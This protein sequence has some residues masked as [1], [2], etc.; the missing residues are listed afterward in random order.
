MNDKANVPGR[1][2][3]EPEDLYRL[4]EVADV[5]LSQPADQVVF[6]VAWPDRETDSNRAVLH[7]V[8][9]DGTNHRVLTEGHRDVDPRFS[10]DGTK[11]AFARL[12]PKQPGRLMVM[13]WPLGEV[14][15]VAQFADG[16]PGHIRWLNGDRLL[17]IA[18]QRPS[19]QNGVDDDEL[20]RR[21]RVISTNRYRFDG[22]GYI[23]DRPNQIWLIDL[24]GQADGDAE[25]AAS[26]AENNDR[27]PRPVGRSGFDHRSFAVAPDG[28]S[29][30]ATAVSDDDPLQ[31]AATRVWRYPLPPAAGAAGGDGPDEA[32]LLTPEKG[33]WDSLVWHDDGDLWALGSLDPSETQFSQMFQVDLSGESSPRAVVS[34]DVNIN[35]WGLPGRGLIKLDD[36]LLA[37]GIRRGRLAIDHYAKTSGSSSV[38]YEDDTQIRA[39]DADPTGQ[40]VVAA[41]TSPVRPAELWR[42]EGGE[43]KLLVAMNE[44]L[45]S[46]LDLSPVEVVKVTSADGTE[47]EGFVV[48]PPSSAPDTGDRRPGLIYV[49]GGPMGQYGYGF[50]DEFQVAAARGY[51]VIG[52]NPRGSDGYGEEW[53]RSIMGDYGHADW[54]DVQALTGLL[55]DLPD[56]DAD[57]IGIGGGSYGGFMTA[58][59]LSHDEEGRYKAGLVERS[60]VCWYS[61]YGTSDIGYWFNERN[62]GATIEDDLDGVLRQAPL[63]YAARISAPTLIVHSEEDWRCS[64]EQAEQLFAAI[65]RN[66]GDA[67]LVRFPG[68][69]H[70]LSRSGQPKHRVERFEIVHEFYACHLGGADFGTSHLG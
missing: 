67:I 61:M 30:A 5:A 22:R 7:S 69:N 21:P 31:S 25:A 52:G 18:P 56:V 70:E 37:P 39:F 35:S 47:V 63:S 50:F 49:H 33:E 43:A 51:V 12:E 15:E 6:V 57:R 4:R 40:V 45:L 59:A 54:Q 24:T 41:I 16:G 64:I 27:R 68:E 55:S 42:V 58:W 44:Q 48:V 53:A 19:E 1:R 13:D 28:G 9:I 32:Q 20:K 46:E 11:L 62:I 26:E 3:F 65:R 34:H 2:P 8:D 29:L 23:N 14:T 60:V 17:V 36:G 38:V 66:G 10:P